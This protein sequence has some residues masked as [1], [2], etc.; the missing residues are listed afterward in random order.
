MKVMTSQGEIE[1]SELVARDITEE[2]DD[3]RVTATEW[4]LLGVLVRRDV[5]VNP[6]RY[7]QVSARVQ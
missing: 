3:A 5:W 7:P 1:R 6:L 4:Y 2:S